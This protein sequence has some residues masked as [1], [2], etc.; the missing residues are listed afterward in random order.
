MAKKSAI[1]IALDLETTGLHTEQDAILEVAAIKFQGSDI[2]DTFESFVSPGRS[3]P[4]RVQRLTGIKPE[5]LVGAP[6][7]DAIS[8]KL[9]HFIGDYPI[10]GHS[11]PFDVGFLRRWGVAR[12]NPL[13]DTFELA[14]VLLP[15]LSSYNL[16]QVAHALGIQVPVDRHRAMVDTVLAMKVFLALYERL[17]AVDLALLQDL[18]HLDAPRSWSLLHFFRQEVRLRQ[19]SEGI[20]GG[21]MRGSLGDRFA[22]QLGMDPRILSFAI[23]RRQEHEPSPSELLPVETTSLT[24]LQKDIE[25]IPEESQAE[26]PMDHEALYAA[27]RTSF[28]QKTPF[29]LEVTVGNNDY[30]PA[31]LSALEWLS[32]TDDAAPRRLVV[33]C[34]NQQSARRLIETTL[35]G[36]QAALKSKLS[37]A[38]WAEKGGYLCT[39]RWFGAAL[40]RTS[41][42]LTA[43]Q[44]RGLAKLGLW[45]QQTLTGE[46]SELTLLPQEVTAWERISSGIEQIPSADPRAGSMYQRCMY[47]RK[48]YCFVSNAAE[49]VRNAQIV[50]TTHA[51][52]L[53]DLSQAH[54][55]LA[56][57]PTRMILDADLLD[58]ECAR[59]SSVE[60]DYPR[61]YRLL[62]TIGAELADGRYQGL[63]ALAAPALRENGPGGISRTQTIAKADLDSRLVSWFQTIK[64]ARSSVD[65]LFG[66]L[67][68]LTD[69]FLHQGGRD[70]RD[71]PR[72]SHRLH[73]RLDQPLRL[74]S[75]V[76]N[77][78]SWS[79][80]IQLWHQTEQRLQQVIDLAQKAEKG[81][82]GGQRQGNARDKGSGEES[83][84]ASE[85]AGVASQLRELKHLGQQAFSLSDSENVYWLRQTQNIT[86]AS[87][88]QHRTSPAEQMPVLYA[89]TIQTSQLLRRLLLTEGKATV[90]AG[91]ALSVEQ[92]FAFTRQ[93]LGL[94][95]GCP[96]YSV[97][98]KRHKQTLLLVPSDVPEPNA[99][100]YQRRLEEALIQIATS[101]EGQ[102]VALFTSHAALR[103]SYAAIKPVLEA[104]G[105]LVLGQGIDGSPRHLWQVYK[106][107]ERV[108]L[109]GAGGFWEGTDEVPHSPACL[110]VARLPMPVLNDPPMAARAELISDQLHQLTVP[111][112]SLR[113]RRAL[114]RLAWNDT[115]RNAI[116]IF[117]RRIIS[118]EYGSMILHS[119]PRSSQRQVIAQEL[120][121]TLLDWLTV[122]DAWEDEPLTAQK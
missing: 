46:R 45:A 1:R 13:V 42:E 120:S 122:M 19:E 104:R 29:L 40:R 90:F 107:Q 9:Q 34:A 80:V 94:E 17:Q 21:L 76:S 16:G 115:R 58:E 112:A 114:N 50:V 89:Q 55:L 116:V 33:A 11:I 32:E 15:S 72:H 51:G 37:V 88:M 44:A 106:E 101:L 86:T 84:L 113:M 60:L 119:L 23:A 98:S 28:E 4:Y 100:Q 87:Q 27:M 65:A 2:L 26:G 52:L 105:I 108:V 96:A 69:E 39:H 49:R 110:F 22:S 92:S 75:Q 30:A 25:V 83:S 62:N 79:N 85:L 5:L 118:K 57:I 68:Q 18:A 71:G 91:A 59:W 20:A 56:E 24:E 97:V 36:I 8:K 70:R 3:I 7:F 109:L 41:G 95:D 73:E 81:L 67:Q 64:Q 61:L 35:P 10:V 77:L 78:P 38:Y 93:R 47:R 43:E 102:V 48:G 63:L 99:P 103:S 74:T 31:L 117:D 14:T 6:P 82:L 54:S 53:D 111:L 66:A 121:E 12:A